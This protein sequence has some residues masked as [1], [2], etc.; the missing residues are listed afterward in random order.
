MGDDDIT[1]AFVVVV[2]DATG[3]DVGVVTGGFVV[4]AVGAAVVTTA[5]GRLVVGPLVPPHD[6]LA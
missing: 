4:V 3:D 5:E 2:G 1:G 6:T